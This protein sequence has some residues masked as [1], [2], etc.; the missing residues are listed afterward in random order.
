MNQFNNSENMYRSKIVT[1]IG[2]PF[3]TYSSFMKGPALAPK[4]IRESFHSEAT[5]KCTEGKIDLGEETRF[6]DKGDIEITDYLADIEQ[7]ITTFLETG[8]RIISL[9]GDHSITYPIVRAFNKKFDNLNILQLD[10]H[11][12]LYHEFDGNPYSHACPF[13][14]IMEE[15]LVDRLVQIGIRSVTPHLKQ[16]V[17]RFN[18]EMIDMKSWDQSIKIEFEG[19]LYLSLDL[20]VLDPAFTPGVSHHE[21]GGLTSREVISIIQNLNVTIVGADIVELNPN[22][23]PSGITAAV[24]AK[25]LKEISGKMLED[26]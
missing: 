6:I 22:R 7:S 5:N 8:T 25:F 2:I 20:D 21:P 3:D 10:A 18:V 15:N 12:D 24:A 13:A 16:Q 4:K 19:P 9:G 23:D 17:E 26:I 11:P 1:V 14:R